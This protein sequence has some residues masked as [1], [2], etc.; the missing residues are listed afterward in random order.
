M[1]DEGFQGPVTDYIKDAKTGEEILIP[2]LN[3][4]GMI[5]YFP[6]ISVRPLW[7]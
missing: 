5:F 3:R 6:S 7:F 2:K 1:F 4:Y